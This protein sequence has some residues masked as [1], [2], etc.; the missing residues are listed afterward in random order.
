MYQYLVLWKNYFYSVDIKVLQTPFPCMTIIG[1][2]STIERGSAIRFQLALAPMSALHI[3]QLENRFM[4][5]VPLRISDRHTYSIIRRVSDG[6]VS[7]VRVL[8][9]NIPSK[10]E[11]LSRDLLSIDSSWGITRHRCNVYVVRLAKFVLDQFRH[12]RR[13]VTRSPHE[14]RTLFSARK[15]RSPSIRRYCNAFAD[16]CNSANSFPPFLSVP[17]FYDYGHRIYDTPD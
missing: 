4:R 16:R 1:N 12:C 3:Y 8:Q 10:S 14:S 13:G 6:A 11:P 9:R 17:A 7:F 15:F 2:V 5:I